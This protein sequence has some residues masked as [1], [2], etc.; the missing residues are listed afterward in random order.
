MDKME[1]KSNKNINYMSKH[2]NICQGCEKTVKIK[3]NVTDGYQILA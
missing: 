1:W 3:K 2:W